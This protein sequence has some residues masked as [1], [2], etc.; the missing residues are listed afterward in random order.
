MRWRVSSFS[1]RASADRTSPFFSISSR[2]LSTSTRR[3]STSFC[4]VTLSFSSC[5]RAATPATDRTITRWTSTYPIRVPGG[6]RAGDEP[7]DQPGD[8]E[9]DRPD[10]PSVSHGITSHGLL[11]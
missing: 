9:R 11:P 3:L 6:L 4:I 8:E 1:R 10:H 2:S 5:S 7:A